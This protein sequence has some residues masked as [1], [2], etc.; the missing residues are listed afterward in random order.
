M[1][2]GGY[3]WTDRFPAIAAEARLLGLKTA[4]LDGEAVVLD[5][6]GR[7]EFGMLQRVLGSHASAASR[8]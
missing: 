8:G 4:I 6:H 5:E 2:R 7:S 1:T 3:D